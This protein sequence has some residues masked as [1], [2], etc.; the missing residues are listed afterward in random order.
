[1]Y[2][3]LCKIDS[4]IRY[5]QLRVEFH[6]FIKSWNGLKKSLPESFEMQ[7]NKSESE[8]E[9]EIT[10]LYIICYGILYVRI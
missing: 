10:Y 2:E 8:N 5:D 6:N 1:L 7:L 3:V 4:D 9:I